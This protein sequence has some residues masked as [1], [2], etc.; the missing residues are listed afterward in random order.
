MNIATAR[1]FCPG[2]RMRPEPELVTLF[3]TPLVVYD[4]PDSAPL[5]EELRKVIEARERAH[6]TTQHSNLGGW[7]SSWDMERWAGAPAIKL[8][9]MA[10]NVANRMTT[11]RVGKAGT[12]RTPA[13][14]P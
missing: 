10:R 3:A 13:T 12:V 6:P 14:S 8:L 2:M 9:A 4:V 11:D 1:P 7:Q 5:N